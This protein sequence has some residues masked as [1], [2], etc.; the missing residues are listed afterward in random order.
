M[1]SQQY[2]KFSSELKSLQALSVDQQSLF[3]S[4]AVNKLKVDPDS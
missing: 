2:T 4:K 1:Y 3:I